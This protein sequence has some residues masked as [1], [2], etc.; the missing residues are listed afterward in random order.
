MRRVLELESNQSGRRYSANKLE[1][2]Q[3]VS[4]REQTAQEQLEECGVKSSVE[5]ESS[6]SADKRGMGRKSKEC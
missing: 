6:I 2:F 3:S 5:I 4:V 1:S